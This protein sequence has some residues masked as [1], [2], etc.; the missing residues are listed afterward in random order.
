[1]F[2]LM[3]L[4]IDI[5]LFSFEFWGFGLF[6]GVFLVSGCVWVCVEDFFSVLGVR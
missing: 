6:E 2:Y 3:L 5:D 1:M 4:L